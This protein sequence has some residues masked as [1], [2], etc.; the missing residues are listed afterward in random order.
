MAARV[1][2]NPMTKTYQLS[3]LIFGNATSFAPIMIGIAKLP[4]MAGTAGMR[5]K[6]TMATPCMVNIRLYMSADMTSP[7]GVINSSRIM[8][9][10]TPPSMN[11]I[12]TTI[13]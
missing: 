5:T 4:R 10:K 6:N 12:T 3:R 9:A 8:A 7:C 11:A 2:T 13:R 1:N